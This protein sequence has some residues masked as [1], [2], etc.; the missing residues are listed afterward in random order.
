MGSSLFFVCLFVFHKTHSRISNH[1][2]EVSFLFLYNYSIFLKQK[3][4]KL[5]SS[6]HLLGDEDDSHPSNQHIIFVDSEREGWL[7]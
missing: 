7:T 3:I 2:Q 6:L 4:E 5:Q 1:C